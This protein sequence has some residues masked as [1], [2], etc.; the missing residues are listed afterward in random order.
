MTQGAQ[1]TA[2]VLCGTADGQAFN[3]TAPLDTSK[4]K[5]STS[6]HPSVDT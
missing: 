1:V 5:N 2:D 3:A 4:G 6:M